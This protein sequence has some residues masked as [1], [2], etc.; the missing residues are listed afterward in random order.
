MT[1]AVIVAAGQG[2]RMGAVV[3][4][5]FLDAAGQPIIAHTW[6]RLDEHPEIDETILVIREGAREDFVKLA[7]QLQPTKPFQLI[8]GGAQRQDSVGNG[9]AAVHADC[10]FIAIHDGARPCVSP[11]I[12]SATLAAAR[13][14]GAAVAGAPVADTLKRANDNGCIQA[15]MDRDGLWAVHT[16]QVFRAEIIRRAMAAVAKQGVIITD[17]TAACELIGQPVALVA[18]DG[19]NPKVTTAADLPLIA[20]LLR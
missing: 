8:L 12:I 4:K 5:L 6:R 15:N 1:S 19:P 7:G 2:K 11:G 13:D 3:D 10:D 9:I 20:A 17:D 16:P 14:T 18:G